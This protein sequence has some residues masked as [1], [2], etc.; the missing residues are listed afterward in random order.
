METIVFDLETPA[1]LLYRILKENAKYGKF[2][3]E[4]YKCWQYF[5]FVINTC[6]KYN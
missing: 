5:S 3:A 4:E 6:Q 2:P 1:I